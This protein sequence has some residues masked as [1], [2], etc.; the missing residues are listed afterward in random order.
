MVSRRHARLTLLRGR[1]LFIGLEE[2]DAA[3]LG[4]PPIA[5]PML[6]QRPQDH[7]ID[8]A[9]KAV[10]VTLRAPPKAGPHFGQM[11]SIRSFDVREL[12]RA[13]RPS[14]INSTS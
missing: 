5:K 10:D 4:I 1:D 13:T 12:P 9:Q 6:N 2:S 8:A 3:A 7:R 11:F 14:A